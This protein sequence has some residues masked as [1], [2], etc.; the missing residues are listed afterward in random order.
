MIVQH[1]DVDVNAFD[2]DAV[3]PMRSR[4]FRLLAP[5]WANPINILGTVLVLGVLVE[6]LIGRAV[7]PYSPI[8]PDYG[9]S[10]GAPSLQ[11]FFGTDEVGRDVFS[12]VLAGSSTAMEVIL[13]VVGIGASVG[14]LIGLISGYAGGWIDEL[15]MR[16]TD[17]FLAFPVLVLAIA[18]AAILGPSLSHT[19]LALT[20]LW[21]PW[22]ARLIRGQVLAL[23]EREYIE[24]AK[25][26]GV[27][28]FRILW[29]HLLPNTTGPLLVQISLDLGYALLAA[30]SLSFIGL[31][32]QQP[33]P[34]WGLMINDAQPYL[35][36][37]WWVGAFPGLAIVLAVLG[38][39]LLGDALGE[40]QGSRHA[41]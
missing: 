34:D 10:F 8:L 36:S 1:G 2:G 16:V 20:V 15:L 41:R 29:R 4:R 37:D 24:A 19:M 5:L 30:S 40:G 25:A 6:A 17:I 18:I 7:A 32:V 31:G 23:R 14:T 39:N 11:H 33:E 26:T 21:W 12:R 35:R 28:P 22:Y 13:V 27:P 9:S 3:I 38:F